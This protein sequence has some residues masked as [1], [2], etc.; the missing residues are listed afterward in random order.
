[1]KRAR[2][3][4][5]ILQRMYNKIYLR[6]DEQRDNSEDER[7]NAETRENAL[8]WFRTKRFAPSFFRRLKRVQ[9]QPRNSL[10][11]GLTL[12]LSMSFSRP[13]NNLNEGR[14]Y[15]E[16]GMK[17]HWRCILRTS[18]GKTIARGNGKVTVNIWWLTFKS[19]HRENKYIS[20]CFFIIHYCDSDMDV[21][22]TWL[23]SL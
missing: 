6:R 2:W 4:A 1:M 8:S 14:E 17:F 21:I 20:E 12:P 15:T 19:N 3:T 5:S 11:L 16:H 18:V 7:E 22:M 10:A 23:V 9:V 13:L